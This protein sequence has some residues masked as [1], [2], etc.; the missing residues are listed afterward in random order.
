MAAGDK[1]HAGLCLGARGAL[2]ARKGELSAAEA[3][4]RAARELLGE[5]D[6]AFSSAVDI[7]RAQVDL[8]EAEALLRQMLAN[9]PVS[10]R[11]TLEAVNNGLEMPM[12]EA[13]YLE[14]SLF[15]LLSTTE[16]KQEGTTAF[17][18]KRSPKFQGK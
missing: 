7:Y 4:F 11:F 17:L 5:K 3:D 9:A 6:L 1:R 2:R 13:Q 18:E 8:S 10:L 16:D 14:A 15:A 12:D